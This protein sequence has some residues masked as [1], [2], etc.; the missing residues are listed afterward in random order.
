MY[1]QI[2]AYT[3]NYLFIAYYFKKRMI[4]VIQF[5]DKVC[6]IKMGRTGDVARLVVATETSV[7]GFNLLTLTKT[8]RI[9]TIPN[10]RG[11]CP[12][13]VSNSCVTSFPAECTGK[14]GFHVE[15]TDTMM[16][17][18]LPP[19]DVH[20]SALVAVELS[21]DGKLVATAAEKTGNV[22]VFNIDS[23]EKVLE[24]RRDNDV[25]AVALSEDGRYL[26]VASTKG[27][28]QVYSMYD[29][30]ALPS[31]PKL[32]GFKSKFFSPSYRVAT[33]PI[34]KT[35]AVVMGFSVGNILVIVTG[36]S[37]VLE[38]KIVE[39][40]QNISYEIKQEVVKLLDNDELK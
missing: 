34:P 18:I 24:F 6:N 1:L 37:I 32:S 19:F 22:R 3:F 36:E 11:L 10:A 5:K 28:C 7:T 16:A 40:G 23:E 35:K 13:T 15:D 27:E 12:F 38:A 30:E 17:E 25:S 14:L 8:F 20:E 39:L 31:N 2:Y 9:P 26:A 33:I 21:Q 4:E 29:R